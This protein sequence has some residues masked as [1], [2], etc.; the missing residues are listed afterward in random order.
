MIAELD[1]LAKPSS[2]GCLASTV[3]YTDRSTD[4]PPE[5]EPFVFFVDPK[6]RRETGDTVYENQLSTWTTQ[7][8]PESFHSWNMSPFDSRRSSNLLPD[9]EDDA[10]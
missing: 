1:R 5:I 8:N 10:H 6:W 3:I 4:R 7:A 9:T 2:K